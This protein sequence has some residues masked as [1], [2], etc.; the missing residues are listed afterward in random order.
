MDST[1]CQSGVNA[2][3]APC[4]IK[5]MTKITQLLNAISMACPFFVWMKKRHLHARRLFHRFL[6]VHIPLSFVYHFLQGVKLPISHRE[7]IITFFKVTDCMFVHVYALICNR[8]IAT[9]QKIKFTRGEKIA[10]CALYSL[11]TVYALR[12]VREPSLIDMVQFS[13]GRIF[14]LG[15]LSL[16]TLCHTKQLHKGI[17]CGSFGSVLYILDPYLGN[18]GHCMFHVILGN[19]HETIYCCF[20]E[21]IDLPLEKLDVL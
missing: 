18:Y 2:N 5:A 16:S 3:L 9:Y 19:L 14:A 17:V 11:N 12:M 21:K 10:R 15:G 20:E 7:K 8:G 13:I 4:N 1:I 6:I